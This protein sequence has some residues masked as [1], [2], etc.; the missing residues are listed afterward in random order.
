[1]EAKNIDKWLNTVLHKYQTLTR[2][3]VTIM[4]SLL[5]AKKVD[6]LAVTGRTKK[7]DSIK[8]KI[9]RKSYK[10]P[11]KQLTDISGIRIIVYFE[12]DVER[13]SDIIEKSFC[14]DKTNSLNKAALLAADQIGYRSV[15]YVCDLGNDRSLLPEFRDLKD[16]KFEFQVRTV[17]QH[18]W[19]E[20]AH[21]RKY[22]FFGKL[23]R[24]IERKLYLYAG[25]LEIADRGF[26]ELSQAIDRY[27]AEVK[28]KTSE[29]SLDIEINSISLEAFVNQWVEK[30]GFPLERISSKDSYGELVRELNEFGIQTLSD[31]N[32]IIPENY[33]A[34]A[35]G[36]DYTTNIYGLVRDWM[37]LHDYKK[38]K[39][40]VSYR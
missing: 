27:I 22:K 12:S 16:L 28:N 1:M 11:E 39:E 32:F 20:L 35:A 19:A 3:V 30:T 9:K 36:R 17:L 34:K 29:A 26:D 25:L 18:A 4:K 13:V 38:Y 6:Y 10:H 31:L 40:K 37:L 24:G 33:T 8:D 15:H 2:T 21:D 5:Q 14:V 7:A 23:P